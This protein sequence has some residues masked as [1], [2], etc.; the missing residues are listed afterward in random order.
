[1]YGY[2]RKKPGTF[3]LMIFSVVWKKSI[4]NLYKVNNFYVFN[5]ILIIIRK[6]QKVLRN[7]YFWE[8]SN[9]FD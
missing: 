8:E 3:N 6:Y 9:F 4:L 5:K 1:M 7:I 2:K